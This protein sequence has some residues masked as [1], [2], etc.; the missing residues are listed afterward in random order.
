MAHTI[1]KSLAAALFLLALS[2]GS[3]IARDLPTTTAR[4]AGFSEERLAANDRFYHAK[5]DKGEMAGIVVLIARHGKIAHF[6]A[7]GYAD[8]GTQRAM[9]RDSFF[10]LYSMT[11][12]IAAT[13]LMMLYEEGKFQ[14]DDPVSK[15]IPEFKGIRVL[16]TPTSPITDTVPAVRE[17]TIHDLLRFT[18]GFASGL[19]PQNSVDDAYL[20]AG[21]RDHDISLAESMQRLARIPLLYQPGKTTGYGVAS[22]IQARLVEIF[23]GKSFEDFL[24][25]RLFEPLGMSDTGFWVEP[26]VARRLVSVH[27]SKQGKIVPMGKQYGYP[28]PTSILVEPWSVEGY[29]KRKARTGGASGLAGTTEDYWRFAQMLAN[30]GT[31]EGRRILSP[32]TVRY[33]TRDHRSFLFDDRA[34]EN[35]R[36]TSWGLGFAVMNNPAQAGF[37]SFEGTF[38]WHG[39]AATTFWIDPEK[40]LVVVAMTQ[41]MASDF[42]LRVLIPEFR[43]LVY[44]AL[45]E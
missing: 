5:I 22:D 20:K 9:E 30:G 10:R 40:E 15:Y 25:E 26:P 21:L 28:K 44:S 39:A 18:D 17:P 34:P 38:F 32:N 41:H 2:Q 23:S 8:T 4:D 6:K 33:M 43:T 27:W 12:P 37:M 3:A 7:I 24:N 29:T 11:K 13:A 14:L 16:R 31:F 19:K 36:G 45:M 35:S 1:V 42:D